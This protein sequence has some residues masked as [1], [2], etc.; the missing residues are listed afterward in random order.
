MEIITYPQ[1]IAVETDS[2]ACQQITIFAYDFT[3][4]VNSLK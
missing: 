4:L 2:T 3:E 1:Y